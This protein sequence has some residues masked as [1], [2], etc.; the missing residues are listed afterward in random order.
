[1]RL[2]GTVRRGFLGGGELGRLRAR[3]VR[4]ISTVWLYASKCDNFRIRRNPG[5]T[6]CLWARLNCILQIPLSVGDKVGPHEVAAT[7]GAGG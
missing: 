5:T 3:A 4:R 1:M 2:V 6:R 7:V